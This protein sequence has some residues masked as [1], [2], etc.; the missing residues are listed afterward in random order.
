[1]EKWRI[2]LVLLLLSISAASSAAQQY[3]AEKVFTFGFWAAE[4]RTFSLDFESLAE[5]MAKLNMNCL[6]AGPPMGRYWQSG[7]SKSLDE[8]AKQIKICEEYGIYTLPFKTDLSQEQFKPYIEKFKDSPMILG[9]YIKDEPNPDYLPTFLSF[10]KLI[11][12]ITPNQPA[13]CLFYRPDSAID[14]TPHQPLV[15]SDCYPTAWIHNG[16]SI[17]PHFMHKEL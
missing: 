15:L 10:K 17:G 1:M 13:I 4:P 6:V 8:F 12:E 2:K 14:F 7:K 3:A 16:T 5:D 9:W 11:E